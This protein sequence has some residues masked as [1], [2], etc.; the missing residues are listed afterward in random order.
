MKPNLVNVGSRSD[1]NVSELRSQDKGGGGGGK[2]WRNKESANWRQDH[3]DIGARG[4]WGGRADGGRTGGEK[5]NSHGGDDRRGK[6]W[7][8]SS[9]GI[10][11]GRSM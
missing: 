6:S 3:G 10:G 1:E 7:K 5:W 9:V 8:D 11:S 2:P 4:K